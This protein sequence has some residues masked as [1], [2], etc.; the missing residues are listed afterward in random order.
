[1]SLGN[2]VLQD[3]GCAPVDALQDTIVEVTTIAFLC[4]ARVAAG[5]SQEEDV[6]WRP[7]GTHLKE[8][9]WRLAQAHQIVTTIKSRTEDNLPAN[10]PGIS[11][12][13]PAANLETAGDR[14][15]LDP[16]PSACLARKD[17]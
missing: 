14:P 1:M 16:Q 5:D 13:Y 12:A 6:A 17:G 11:S 7:L 8:L 15:T 4:L 3:T 2:A 9:A 10:A